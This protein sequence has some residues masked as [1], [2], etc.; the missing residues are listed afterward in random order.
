MFGTLS[1]EAEV[2]VP[3]SKAWALFGTLEIGKVLAGTTLEAVDVVEGDG[4]PGTILKLTFKPGSGFS[5]CK[6][7]FTT[8]DNTNMVKVS[9]A[10]E[11]GFLDIGFNFYRLRIE[12]K[13]NPKDSSRS[14]CLLKFT[15]EYDVKEEF[16]ANASLVTTG[17]LLAIMSVA[18]EH[19]LKSN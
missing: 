7:K 16:A 12:I 17:P 9:E 2:K 1:E 14:S 15:L 6:E 4:G 19:L 8:V 10:V 5:Y 13:E 18:S 11:G 3:A